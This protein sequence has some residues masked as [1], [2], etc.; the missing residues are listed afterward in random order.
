MLCFCIQFQPFTLNIKLK[1]NFL[2]FF[3]SGCCAA[4]AGASGHGYD[5]GASGHGQ[6]DRRYADSFV[7]REHFQISE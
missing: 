5:G 2:L 1:P 7:N 3:L 6:H 4:G